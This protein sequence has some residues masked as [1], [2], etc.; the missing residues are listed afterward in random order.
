[1][2]FGSA[3]MY[4]ELTIPAVRTVPT[5]SC[6]VVKNCAPQLPQY[7]RLFSRKI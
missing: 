6:Q 7:G 2:P 1:M 5:A 4:A 3:T